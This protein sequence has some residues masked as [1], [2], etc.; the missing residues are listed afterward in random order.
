MKNTPTTTKTR[1][2]AADDPNATNMSDQRSLNATVPQ[3]KPVSRHHYSKYELA[4]M[5]LCIA[6]MVAEGV[7]D[8]VWLRWTV[9]GVCLIALPSPLVIQ[10]VKDRRRL[11]LKSIFA[12]F[13]KHGITPVISGEEIR[14]ESKGKM[15][16]MRIANGCQL[17][18][19]REYPLQ[20]EISGMFESAASITMEEVFSAK[21]GVRRPEGSSGSIFFATELFCS[22][23]K[24]LGMILPASVDILDIAEERQRANLGEILSAENKPKKKIGFVQGSL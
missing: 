12:Y 24:E 1:Q 22:S 18:V 21:V 8:L 17:Q 2:S 20:E 9:A 23:V 10:M 11:S 13:R 14:W 6:G 19:Y 16:V 7:I 4:V 5:A 15:N 3:E